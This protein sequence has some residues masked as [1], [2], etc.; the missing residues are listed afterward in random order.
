MKGNSNYCYEPMCGVCTSFCFLGTDF[1][2]FV[3]KVLDIEKG[4]G[5]VS[6]SLLLNSN[7]W[8]SSGVAVTVSLWV[9][10][11]FVSDVLVG[12]VVSPDVLL[13]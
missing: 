10:F 2:L 13:L 8:C 11:C 7:T 6:S 1:G 4:S 12:V 9:G 5:R 3:S